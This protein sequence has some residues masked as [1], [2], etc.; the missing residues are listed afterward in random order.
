MKNLATI[1]QEI[2]VQNANPFNFRPGA[3]YVLYDVR[4]KR[5]IKNLGSYIGMLK[6]H[7]TNIYNFN[8][9]DYSEQYLIKHNNIFKIVPLGSI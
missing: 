4:D 8:D 6:Y 2:K 7:N 3:Q 9:H 5:I 1:L